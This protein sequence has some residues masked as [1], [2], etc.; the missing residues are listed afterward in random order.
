MIWAPASTAAGASRLAF[1]GVNGDGADGAG[2]DGL[3]NAP[4]DEILAQGRTI[5]ALQHLGDRRGGGLRDL[6]DSVLG[7]VVAAIDALEVH[8]GKAAGPSNQP[9]EG[10]ADDGV[11]GGCQDGNREAVAPTV[12][13]VVESSGF[14]V[15]SPGTMD[16]SSKP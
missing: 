11:H 16:T 1:W 2:G 6:V 12:K 13:S 10:G 3:P 8:D 4:G 9:R 15:T 5:D 7:I 14:V